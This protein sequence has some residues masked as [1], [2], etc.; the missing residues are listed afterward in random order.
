PDEPWMSID[1]HVFFQ[2]VVGAIHAAGSK[3]PIM[4]SP[5]FAFVGPAFPPQTVANMAVAFKN[6][7]G[8][9]IEAWQDSVGA[10]GIAAGYTSSTYASSDAYYAALAAALP[11]GALFADVELFTCCVN[12]FGFGGGNYHPASSAR[13]NQQLWGA[14]H[15]SVRLSW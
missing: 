11:L 9:D 12:Q 2:A 1:Q 4:V 10:Q 13:L 5:S 15:A 6:Q 7:T 14:R 3:R 8:V